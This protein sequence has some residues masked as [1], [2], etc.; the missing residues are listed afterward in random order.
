MRFLI[1]ALKG[2]VAWQPVDF[3][4]TQEY[5]N[6]IIQKIMIKPLENMLKQ[7]YDEQIEE[8]IQEQMKKWYDLIDSP[9]FKTRILG[10]LTKMAQAAGKENMIEEYLGIAALNLFE[11][12]EKMTA[13]ERPLPNGWEKSNN[14]YI[15]YKLENTET[16][17]PMM[18]K[19]ANFVGYLARA[20]FNKAGDAIRKDRGHDEHGIIKKHKDVSN[21]GEDEEGNEIS[22]YDTLDENN[23]LNNP[24][25]KIV[26]KDLYKG[27]MKKIQSVGETET[28]MF[29]SWFD[30]VKN[31]V[32]HDKPVKL[33]NVLSDVMNE[34]NLTEAQ[35]R[36][37][38]KDL[39]FIIKNYLRKQSGEQ[40]PIETQKELKLASISDC[41]A[42]EYLRK[43]ICAYILCDQDDEFE[44][45][46]DYINSL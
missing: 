16:L 38:W 33:T 27:L 23:P 21:I 12:C 25:A 26:L 39:T 15:K 46:E 8:D 7:T 34:Y 20:F 10:P 9:A 14:E 19:P 17:S 32:L 6:A 31:K 28:K 40:M 41:V 45:P 5:I 37:R 36:G 1:A 43:Q 13:K 18:E 24:E 3:E 42:Y 44:T 22:V 11:N 2:I 4:S 30:A 35:A 29:V